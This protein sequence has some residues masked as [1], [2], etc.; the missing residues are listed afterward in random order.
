MFTGANIDIHIRKGATHLP[1]A[2]TT[3]MILIGPGT[4]IAP[5]RAIVQSRLNLSS[6]K[7]GMPL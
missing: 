2:P 7:T 6:T 1:I 3:P 4:G 5:V